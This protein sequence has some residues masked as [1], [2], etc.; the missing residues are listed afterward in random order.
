MRDDLRHAL[1]ALGT[2]LTTVAAPLVAPVRRDLGR[3]PMLL[4]ETN[5]A[6][7]VIGLA[8]AAIDA[9]ADPMLSAAAWDDVR[10]AFESEDFAG[11]CELRI[12]QLAELVELGGGDWRSTA[13]RLNRVLYDDRST[14]AA[15]GAIELADRAASDLESANA[16]A[17]VDLEDRLTL[18]RSQVAAQQPMGDVVAWVCFRNASLDQ[19][20]LD[21]G[22]VEF[23]G[24]Q[25]W[26]EGIAGGYPA[27]TSRRDEFDD[28]W[29]K[30]FFDS[31]PAEPFVLARVPLGHGRMTGAVER[32]RS[33]AQDLVRAAR[34]HSEWILIKG[35]AI[36]VRGQ[37]GGWF[38]QRLDGGEE[39]KLDRYA[40]C[41]EP[42][43]G[44]LAKLDPA[45]AQK[46]LSGETQAHEAVR[47]I[48]WAE[49]LRRVAD[50]P[51]RLALSTRLIERALPAPGREH[52][53]DPVT[54]YLKDWWADRHAQELIISTA[55]EAVELLDSVMS[56]DRNDKGWRER[57]FPNYGTEQ[58]TIRLNETLAS[59][60]E[61]VE[62]LPAGSMQRRLAA[63]L[64]FHA[65][66]AADW[67]VLVGTHRQA[68]DILL[69]RLVRQ[70]NA[71]LHGGDTV[72]AVVAS[73][74]EFSLELQSFVIYEQ[75]D[76][77]TAEERL[78]TALERNR[79]MLERKYTR[80]KATD[81]PISAMFEAAVPLPA[82][83]DKRDG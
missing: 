39:R 74:E 58:G 10:A 7:A 55:E 66:S 19:I 13:R 37:E 54:R 14:L 9:L 46:L 52:W 18:A 33:A 42:T 24:H 8:E 26:P 15:I 12:K 78:L 72:P 77:A 16:P 83:G 36:N 70:R 6:L 65:R 2:Q 11:T 44:S 1:D 62:D 25:L 3:L 60:A 79:I 40:P 5:G 61:L 17:G 59:V 31:M 56:P 21:V 69:A 29:H 43:G 50:V 41:F 76:A 75:L 63:E 35:A 4:S 38:G 28:E 34:P 27:N 80:M 81:A 48:E 82:G 51:Q 68:F 64:A 53:T 67:L 23:F 49:T 32:A 57:L 30:F 73:V 45:L 71:V 22:G 47:D 20:Y